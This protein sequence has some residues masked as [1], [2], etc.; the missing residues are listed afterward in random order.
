[1]AQGGVTLGIVG[2]L[3]AFP[4]RLAARAVTTRGGRLRRGIT[5]QTQRVVFGRK[6]LD[7]QSEAEIEVRIETLRD[8]GIKPAFSL[9]HGLTVS[10]YYRDPEGNFVELQSDCFGDW[11]LSSEWIQHSEEFK[12]NPIGV[13]FDP[14]KVYDAHRSGISFDDLHKAIRDSKYLPREI[15]NIGLPG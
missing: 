7:K 10:I 5:R 8:A 6:L 11:K 14:D 3:R 9:D 1:M 4:Q 2:A 12:A 13:F 15:P